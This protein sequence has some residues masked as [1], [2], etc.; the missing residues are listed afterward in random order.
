MLPLEM[1]FRYLAVL[2]QPQPALQRER[3]CDIQAGKH[4][5]KDLVVLVDVV[6]GVERILERIAAVDAG[7]ALSSAKITGYVVDRN[8]GLYQDV[9]SEN[10]VFAG[11]VIEGTG[12]AVMT[13]DCKCDVLAEVKLGPVERRVDPDAATPEVVVRGRALLIEVV[14]GDGIRIGLPATSDVQVVVRNRC[15][16]ENGF[17]PVGTCAGGLDQGV[18]I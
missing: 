10:A 9:L 12:A 18:G 5:S 11:G 14:E 2:L 16:T 13:I 15:R 1:V 8:D 7:Y 17:P 4:V 6:L 3:R